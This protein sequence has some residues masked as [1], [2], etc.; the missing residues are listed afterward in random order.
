MARSE[1]QFYEAFLDICQPGRLFVNMRQVKWALGYVEVWAGKCQKMPRKIDI[2]TGPVSKTRGKIEPWLAK[3]TKTP[4][5]T[6]KNLFE[7]GQA[8]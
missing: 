1:C 7:T 6:S 8:Q 3:L 4:G 5:K 2:P